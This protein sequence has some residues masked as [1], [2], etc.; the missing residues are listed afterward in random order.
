MLCCR[1]LK[2]PLD[3]VLKIM[4]DDKPA[5]EGL[6]AAVNPLVAQEVSSKT[7]SSSAEGASEGTLDENL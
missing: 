6:V 1:I 2:N 4:I 5:S 7:E 3:Y